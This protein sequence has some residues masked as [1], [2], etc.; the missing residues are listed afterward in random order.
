LAVSPRA[1]AGA[2]HGVVEREKTDEKK[3][4]VRLDACPA[5]S[6]AWLGTAQRS[7]G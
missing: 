5:S 4:F 2:L 1:G 7:A 6:S 3:R